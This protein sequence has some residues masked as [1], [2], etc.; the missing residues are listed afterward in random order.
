MRTLRLHGITRDAWERHGDGSGWMY[1]IE[2]IGYKYNITDIASALGLE[3]LG[4]LEYMW[5]KRRRIARRYNTAFAGCE[6]LHLY[7]VKPGRVSSWYLYPLNLNSEALS[8]DRD[9]FIVEMEE[10][11]I[12]LSVHFIP[13]YRFTYYRE[14]GY[15]STEYPNCEWVFERTLSLPIYPAMD[16]READYVI[17]SV[18]DLVKKHKR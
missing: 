17:E 7:R 14:M 8:I 3:Q 5:K 15:K 12:S 16:D 1:D 18:L 10:R 4:K 9:R 11:G 6:G 2:E 13:L